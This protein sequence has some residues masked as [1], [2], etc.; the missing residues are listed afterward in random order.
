MQKNLVKLPYSAQKV[1]LR[2]LTP[3]TLAIQPSLTWSKWNM[4]E[5]CGLTF[6]SSYVD[7]PQ[8]FPWAEPF[9]D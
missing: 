7:T 4:H 3:N 9:F 2:A 6:H 1:T 8:F 5:I